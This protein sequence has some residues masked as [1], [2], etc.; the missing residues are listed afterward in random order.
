M[1][2]PRILLIPNDLPFQ[3]RR[4]QF[5]LRVSFAL[6]INKAQGQTFSIAGVDLTEP[7]FSHGQLYVACSRVKSNK[8]LFLLAPNGRITN[9]VYKEVL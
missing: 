8:A 3:F 9:V 7:C 1:F 2:V 6:T 5:P 4:L